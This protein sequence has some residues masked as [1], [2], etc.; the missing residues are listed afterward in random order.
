[1]SERFVW[2][3][4]K[5]DC[6]TW[7]HSCIARQRNKISCP[8]SPPLDKFDIPAGRFRHVHIDLIR[9]LPPTEGHRYILS[10]ID[11]LSHWVEAVP[12]PN[13]NAETVAKVYIGSWI[14]RFGCLTTII[15]NQDRQSES[16]LF[17]I[18]CNICGIKK[19]HT[20]AYHPQSNGFVERWHRTL[21]MALRCHDCLWSEAL[22]WMLLGLRSTY[23]PD[24]QG[25]ISKSVFGENPVLLG[26]LI[27]PQVSKD[28]APSPDFVSRMQTHFQQTCL[29][30]PISHSPPET[31]V[32]TTLSDCS[33]VMLR[34]DAVRQP[35]KPPHLG[36]N[37]VLRWG[38]TTF[39]MIKD[40]TQTVSLH[41]LKPVHRP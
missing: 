5:R 38:D 34:D 12:P 17:T 25:T 15:T 13:I 37:K 1:M 18:L 30:L 8:T 11:H 9:P 23:K 35:F 36:P 27:L 41:C 3:N 7:A 10:P 24:L 6:Q 22:L 16:S 26:E 32:P 14:A 4:I 33:H 40:H 31:N 20:T 2:K 39:D 19:I 29:H 21:K 28:L